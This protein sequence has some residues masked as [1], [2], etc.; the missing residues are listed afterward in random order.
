MSTVSVASEANGSA[1]TIY[2]ARARGKEAYGDT[3]GQAI[4]RL[5]SDVAEGEG[6]LVVVVQS[7]R[8]D[9]F[10][11]A[12]QQKRLIELR[13]KANLAHESGGGL[14]QAEQA[15]LD[16]LIDAELRGATERSVEILRQSK[17]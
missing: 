13:E 2:R 11:T 6:P 8:G 12:E 17:T 14:P 9:R 7:F 3:V 16:A 15:E 10:F 4:D 1:T 5:P